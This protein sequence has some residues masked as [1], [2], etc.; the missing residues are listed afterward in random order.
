MSALS[1]RRASLL[2]RASLTAPFARRVHRDSAR[3]TFVRNARAAPRQDG[4][5]DGERFDVKTL[6]E[7]SAIM[8][9]AEA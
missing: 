2:I 3:N 4:A 6:Y 9:V 7:R 5:H 1:G 8:D